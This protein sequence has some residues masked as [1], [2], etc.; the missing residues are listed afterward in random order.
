MK[1]LDE[2]DIR[3]IAIRI[4]DNLVELGYVPDC[5]DTDD[6]IEFE[7]QDMI[8][9][10]LEGVLFGNLCEHS[11]METNNDGASVCR[12]CN[13]KE[14]N[15]EIQYKD[16]KEIVFNFKF[17]NLYYWKNKTKCISYED[18]KELCED[19]WMHSKSLAEKFCDPEDL[20][21]YVVVFI[22][23]GSPSTFINSLK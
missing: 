6:E 21:D 5:T 4:V 1:Q 7:V 17:G 8:V 16:S 18:L 20:L 13:E 10:E 2:D 3:D 22:E 19:E 23:K 11:Y 15:E 14:E 9:E 12:F